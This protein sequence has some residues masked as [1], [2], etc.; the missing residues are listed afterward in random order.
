RGCGAGGRGGV[1][2]RGAGARHAS[3]AGAGAASTARRRSYAEPKLQIDLAGVH[4]INVM[5][6]NFI[7][8]RVEIWVRNPRI[9]RVRALERAPDSVL[10]GIAQGFQPPLPYGRVMTSKRCPSGSSK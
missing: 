7:T 2:V 6:I 4:G 9:A 8:C 1:R 5:H 10:V 3:L